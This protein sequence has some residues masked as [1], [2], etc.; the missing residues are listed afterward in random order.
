MSP[1][2]NQLF[3]LILL[4]IF[5]LVTK[6]Q[7]YKI[8]FT[9]D[10]EMAKWTFI[11]NVSDAPGFLEAIPL[12]D[13]DHLLFR[14]L[15]QT[16][17]NSMLSIHDET[18]SLF[19][20]VV[21]DRESIPQCKVV[22]P[23][24]L[25]FDIAATSKRK[26]SALFEIISVNVIINDINDNTPTFPKD[27][28]NIAIPE[29]AVNG[30]SYQI[31][32]AS[33]NDTGVNNSI[34]YYE[35]VG[36][37]N[38]FTLDVERKLDGS[39]SVK[40]VVIGKLD[41]ESID[42]YTCTVIAKDG[43]RPQRSGSMTLNITITDEND[44]A[45][46]FAQTVYNITVKE[47][48]QDGTGIL[49]LSAT[50]YDINENSWVLYRLS[51]HQSDFEELKNLFYINEHT[52]VLSVIG[53]LIYEPGKIYKIII[54]AVDQGRPPRLSTNQAIVTV[55][56]EDTGNNPPT[57][58]INLL[59]PGN[60]RVVNV[61]ELSTNGT[62]VAHVEV[63]DKDTGP[64]G[65]VACHVGDPAFNLAPLPNKG[66]KVVVAKQL[67]RERQDL[68]TVV[69]TCLDNGT[70]VLS[71]SDSFLV[72]VTD[73]N[74][75][76]PEFT[77]PTYF[78]E[79]YEGNERGDVVVSVRAIDAD[80]GN[81]SKLEY[82]L[83][84]V[85]RSYFAIDASTGVVRALQQFDR[86]N[87]TSWTFKVYARDFGKPQLVGEATVNLQIK[88]KNDNAPKFANSTLYFYV[89]ENQV[90]GT[91]VNRLT[92]ADPDLNENG[93][94]T[95][96]ISDTKEPKLP[97][98][99]FPEGVLVTKR[100]LDREIKDTYEFT[101][102]AID[103]G[104]PKQSSSAT[105][106]VKVTDVNDMP[107]KIVFPGKDNNTVVIN[108]LKPAGSFVTQIE[109]YDEDEGENSKLSY[110]IEEGNKDRLFML[111]LNSGILSMAQ[112]H[113]VGEN[114]EEVFALVIAVHDG[115][116]PQRSE[117]GQLNVIIKYSNETAAESSPVSSGPNTNI[118]IV[119][120]VIMLTVL[121][122]VAIIVVICVIRKFDRDRMK[123][124]NI[125][126][127]KLPNNMTEVRDHSAM[128]GTVMTRPY[129]KIDSLKK[130]KEV[131][132]SF[133]DDLGGL[134]DHEVSFSNNSVFADS[135]VV[136]VP[137]H[138][139]Q[140]SHQLK[141]FQLQQ[142]LLNSQNP[143][144]SPP[145]KTEGMVTEKDSN[146]DTSQETVTSDSGR[147][148]S[149]DDIPLSHNNSKDD[150]D[151]HLSSVNGRE[152]FLKCSLPNR[153][154]HSSSV[155]PDMGRVNCTVPSSYS[156]QNC[157]L[158]PLQHHSV[159][160]NCS[161]SPGRSSRPQSTDLTPRVPDKVSVERS[162]SNFVE[163]PKFTVRKPYVDKD[164][165]DKKPDNWVP[166]YV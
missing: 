156:A 112:V 145:K 151:P 149:D 162:L 91:S 44:N 15:E 41:R 99:L 71:S 18:G 63:L 64:N 40:L 143:T 21:I 122:S 42:L 131:S 96:F 118:I 105:V 52:G 57:V 61:S 6:A 141:T 102:I 147:G 19:T 87:K 84:S 136:E 20:T 123:S 164:S 53:E 66:F 56:I 11:G 74:D 14:F 130:K 37:R 23:C 90:T 2:S 9:K 155:P 79:M 160:Q 108:H 140:H 65:E 78:E 29:G 62:F 158:P 150:R 92:A 39:L 148:G 111:N 25:S 46:F 72:R 94:V 45:P 115:G 159:Q 13:R 50:D 51:P 100:E 134:Q 16:M 95:Y 30:S 144:W 73:E 166:S 89:K 137:H 163:K 82:Y 58:K 75:N 146:S 114:E 113:E 27:I 32:S 68:H 70:P 10:E 129:D 12:E 93:V 157:T 139:R 49:Q 69:V 5:P 4:F 110:V 17:I 117:R 38:L 135:G 85:V 138:E 152:Q 126:I 24:I 48:T 124:Q 31:E 128:N 34:Q 119:V 120:V 54:E 33:D 77:K 36:N 22:G 88:D 165:R 8:T 98:E 86:E 97:F 43:G 106:V 161:L 26:D 76:A 109:A 121:L 67:D 28:Q 7:E 127:N 101:V 104:V 55:N 83:D 153:Q 47:D 154:T 132:F 59:P 142:A 107:P 80:T 125:Q 60:G 116:I 103:K 3:V 81:N 35:L 133:E 1:I